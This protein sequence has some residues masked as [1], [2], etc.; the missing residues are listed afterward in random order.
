MNAGTPRAS[1]SRDNRISDRIADA[2]LPRTPASCGFNYYLYLRLRP[3]MHLEMPL[4]TPRLL[5]T[6]NCVE[7][8]FL[9]MPSRCAARVS[10]CSISNSK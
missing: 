8:S 4:P 5:Y 6:A 9:K 10:L 2:E 7:G 1:W 3:L